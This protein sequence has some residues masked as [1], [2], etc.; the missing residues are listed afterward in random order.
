M[1]HGVDAADAECEVDQENG[2][3]PFT[4]LRLF[5]L[6]DAANLGFPPGASDVRTGA[7]GD[8][9]LLTIGGTPG[10]TA[11]RCRSG[12]VWVWVWARRRIGGVT[13][14]RRRRAWSVWKARCRR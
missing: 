14:E 10:G 4:G 2:N 8:D 11:S 12:W 3:S 6:D 7:G 9:T 13:R 1:G 5:P